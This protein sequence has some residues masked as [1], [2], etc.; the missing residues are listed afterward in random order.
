MPPSFWNIR[1][2]NE[3]KLQNTNFSTSKG[4]TFVEYYSIIPK[5][6]FVLYII[7][8]NLHTKFYLNMWM[9]CEENGRTMQIIGIFIR[10]RGMITLSKN[11]S[12]LTNIKLDLDTF[13]INLYTKFNLYMFI[14]CEENER[15]LQI[16]G[17][18]IRPR[19]IILST[20]VWSY[21]ISNL[22]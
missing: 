19:G 12:I 9:N 15:K 16:I 13:M 21:Q 10:S 20:I 1:K 6:E 3:Q 8:I 11:C 17:I 2:E 5:I 22:I 4:H 18:C 14:N 7:L